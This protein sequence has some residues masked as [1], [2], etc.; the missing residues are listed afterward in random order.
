MDKKAADKARRVVVVGG[1]ASGMTAAITAARNG[2]RVTVLE[3]TDRVGKKILVTGNGRCNFS[4][5][6]MDGGCYRS[7]VPE[8]PMRVIRS[9]DVERTLEFFRALGIVPVEKN[10]YLYP[11]SGQANS[12]LDVLRQALESEGAVVRTGVKVLGIIPGK[13]GFLVK[14]E[15]EEL[16]ADAVILAAGSKAAPK[17]GSDGSGYLL[18]KELGHHIIK[19]LPALVQLRC[20][21]TFWKRVSGVRVQAAVRLFSGERGE[22]RLLAEDTG[23]VQMTDYGISGIPVFQ[24]SRFAA[25]ELDRKR[26]V[27]CELDFWPQADGISLEEMLSERAGLLA[28]KPMSEFFTGWFHRKLGDLF[29]FLADIPREMPAGKLRGGTLRRLG[30]TIGHFRTEIA[31]TN[32]FDQAQVC[33]GGVDVSEID[34]DTME[35]RICPGLWFSGEIADVDGICGGY[36][37][38]W[39]WS[40]GYIAGFHAAAPE[41]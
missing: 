30:R 36:N 22:E 38:Q 12:V 13:K 37:L 31:Q 4:N 6:R 8:F 5:L 26:K 7:G 21:E 1:G 23:E 24:V 34:P 2:A 41:L 18:A 14:L 9:F 27:A 40:S 20:R 39:A 29:L 17:T 19:P 10:G 16:R 35:S 28:G 25:R 3:H 32:S 15:G 11:A 33:S